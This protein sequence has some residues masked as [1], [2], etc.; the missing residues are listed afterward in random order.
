MATIRTL[1]ASTHR[2]SPSEVTIVA[3]EP[4]HHDECV[5]SAILD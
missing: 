3:D 1:K 4:L 2:M 5:G